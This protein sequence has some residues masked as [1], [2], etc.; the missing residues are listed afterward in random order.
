MP[1]IA[2]IL[3]N[4]VAEIDKNADAGKTVADDTVPA[5]VENTEGTVE[6]STEVVEPTISDDERNQGINLAK[7]L[8]DPV[9]GPAL[10]DYLATQQ[11]YTK[12]ELKKAVQSGETASIVDD[13]ADAL[14]PGFEYL[15]EKLLPAIKKL[16]ATQVESQTKDI[17]ESASAAQIKHLEGVITDAQNDFSKQFYDGKELPVALMTE[18]NRLSNIYTPSPGADPKDHVLN[19]LHMAKGRVAIAKLGTTKV[20]TKKA[21]ESVPNVLALQKTVTPTISGNGKPAKMSLKESAEAALA[22]MNIKE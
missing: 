19:L 9:L 7:A 14:P 18:V 13:L 21:A 8:K 4:A 12:G 1:G 16:V 20:P 15:G 17:R 22:S 6:E 10:I 3:N 5:N 2:E 11:G